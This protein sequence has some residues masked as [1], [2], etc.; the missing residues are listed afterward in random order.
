M[1]HLQ[2]MNEWIGQRF[3]TGFG[4]G[5]KDTAKQRIDGEIEE[6][7]LEYD[8]NPANF[9]DY[10]EIYPY[11]E[12]GNVLDAL[13][14]KLTKDAKE[15]GY[16]GSVKIREP[17]DDR[18]QYAGKKFIMYEPVTTGLQDTGSAAAS[19]YQNIIPK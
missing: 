11:E 18:S 5:E 19:G 12:Y 2:K 3:I 17:L 9:V 6:A 15:N 1:K 13:R 8:D 10:E 14:R 4:P 16:R 7:L